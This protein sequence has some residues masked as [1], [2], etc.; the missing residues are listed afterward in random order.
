MFTKESLRRLIIPLVI[1]QILAVTIGMSDTIMVSSVGE[2]AVSG[3]SIVDTINILLIN[4]FAA[5]ATG[6]AVLTS[7][8]LGNRDQKSANLS[9]KQ[10]IL[11]T[12]FLATIIMCVV[13]FASSGILRLVF[14]HVDYAVMENALIYFKISAW[15]YP[16]IALYNSGAALFRSMG[17]SKIS[18]TTS[19]FMNAINIVGNAILIYGFQMGV[20]GAAISS[21]FARIVGAC[22]MLYLLRSKENAIYI[23]NYREWNINGNM[24]KKILTI[25]I[26]NG[27]E[28]GMFQ[29]GKILVQG[30]VA[31][32]GTIA[33]AS[34]AVANNIAQMEVIPG[35]AIGLAMIS[36]VGRCV[37][38]N[39]YDQARY[40]MKKLVKWA[41]VSMILLNIVILCF[42][43]YILNI[44]NLS[45]ETSAS[46]LHL[47]WIHGV[48]AMLLWPASFTFPNALRASGDVRFTMCVSIL[49]MW[50][51][52]ICLSYVFG[53]LL[54]LGVEGVW[55]AMCSDWALRVVCFIVR[56]RSNKWTEKRLIA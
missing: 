13:L 4:I 30:F 6:G 41:Y 7:Q 19:L 54:G 43:P 3:L 53:N 9:A 31:G 32:F 55:L 34:N 29:I 46:A 50:I 25:G 15:S 28:N 20:A 18:M 37:G 23:D 42:A 56:Y 36:V 11:S 27:L 14:G 44:Y 49:S 22:F 52:R 47:L 38:A 51:C 40:Y 39:D 24:I 2:A 5:L 45:S 26:P 8:Y 21:L 33:I 35:A 48:F 12:A 1:E 10:L 17:N 16:F